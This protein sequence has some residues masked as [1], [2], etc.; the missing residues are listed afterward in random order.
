ML[1]LIWGLWLLSLISI[2]IKK[3]N[4]KYFIGFSILIPLIILYLLNSPIVTN[5]L[6]RLFDGND[7]SSSNAF[8]AR[9]QGYSFFDNLSL[10]YK[11]IGLG[12][13]SMPN[14]NIFL[15]SI[16]YILFGG[17]FIGLFITALLFSRLL[18]IQNSSKMRVLVI[19]LIVLLFATEWLYIYM[20]VFYLS[21]ICYSEKQKV[22]R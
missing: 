13:G 17:G 18:L 6:S 15:P 7:I 16:V 3:G 9:F 21:I 22:I 1:I 11:I 5:T 20:A 19:V 8:I 10:F 2:K 12:F 4:I 14:Y